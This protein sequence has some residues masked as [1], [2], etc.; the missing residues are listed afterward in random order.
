MNVQ[1]YIESGILESYALGLLSEREQKEVEAAADG[2]PAIRQALKKELE[3]IGSFAAAYALDPPAEL[4]DRVLT[5]ALQRPAAAKT[6]KKEKTKTQRGT[7]AWAVAATLLFLLSTGLNWRQFQQQKELQKSLTETQLEIAELESKNEILVTDYKALESDLKIL[8][9]PATE[10]IIMAATEGREES[11]R[12]DILYNT[13]NKV[14]YLDIKR[15]PP[16]PQGRDYQLWALKDGK[17]I[18]MGIF[19]SVEDPLGLGLIE[20][21]RVTEA[22]AFAVTLEPAGGAAQ[23]NLEAMY[24]FGERQA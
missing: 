17:P 20:V 22:D 6:L 8:R 21:G 19:K 13:I 14:V 11:L 4:R 10:Q 5:A 1:E 18:D 12:A 2:S 23:P 16:A 24:V 7:R 15:L 3:S 9:S